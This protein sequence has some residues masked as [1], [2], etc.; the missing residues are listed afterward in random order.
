MAKKPTR[1]TA[2]QFVMFDRSMWKRS[3]TANWYWLT[4]PEPGRRLFSL[5]QMRRP[6]SPQTWKDIFMANIQIGRAHVCTPVTN[7]HLVCRLLLDKKHLPMHLP[8]PLHQLFRL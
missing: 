8:Y 7:A 2:L 3:T 6:N 5:S 1:A 4:V